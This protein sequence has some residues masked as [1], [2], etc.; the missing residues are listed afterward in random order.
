MPEPFVVVGHKYMD[1][2]THEI[3]EVVAKRMGANKVPEASVV[4]K[5]NRRIVHTLD[6]RDL[7]NPLRYTRL[8]D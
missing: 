6:M 4:S 8:R 3:W 5:A 7:S 2:A 1:R